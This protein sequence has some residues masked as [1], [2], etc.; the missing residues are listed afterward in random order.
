MRPES[1]VAC[2][3]YVDRMEKRTEEMERDPISG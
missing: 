1:K 2:S 3:G